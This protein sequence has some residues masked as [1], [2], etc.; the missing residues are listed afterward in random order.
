MIYQGLVFPHWPQLMILPLVAV[1]F[2]SALECILVSKS[3]FPYFARVACYWTVCI[4]LLGQQDF[5]RSLKCLFGWLVEVFCVTFCLV[6]TL[7]I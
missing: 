5:P 1:F 4:S 6:Y 7:T 2:F 3:P